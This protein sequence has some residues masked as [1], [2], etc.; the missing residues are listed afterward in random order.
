MVQWFEFSKVL[1]RLSSALSFCNL[2]VFLMAYSL[3]NLPALTARAADYS[4]ANL[5]KFEDHGE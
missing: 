5:M 3:L 1:G 4:A 2:S